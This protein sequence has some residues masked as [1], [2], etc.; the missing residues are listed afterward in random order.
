MEPLQAHPNDFARPEIAEV[1][2]E[3]RPGH[4]LS[5]LGGRV[6]LAEVLVVCEAMASRVLS[7]QLQ[8]GYDTQDVERGFSARADPVKRPDSWLGQIG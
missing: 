1:E 5:G 8:V 2:V 7:L 3:A 4:Q 6:T